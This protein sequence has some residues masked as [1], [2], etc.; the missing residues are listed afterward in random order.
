MKKKI[1]LLLFI[2]LLLQGCSIGP[3][4]EE[5]NY[6]QIQEKITL[7]EDFIYFL[8]ADNCSSCATFNKTLKKVKKDVEVTFYAIDGHELTSDQLSEFRSE[9]YS[10]IPDWYFSQN[11]YKTTSIYTPTFIKYVDGKA[12]CS[13]IGEIPYEEVLE[14]YDF[15]M[16]DCRF[17]KN[18]QDLIEEQGSFTILFYDSSNNTSVGIADKIRTHVNQNNKTCYYLKN[19]SLSTTEKVDLLSIVNEGRETQLTSL[20]SVTLLKYD[21]GILS[22]CKITT[23]TDA[24]ISEI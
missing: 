19:K 4:Y 11:G 8:R 18:Y 20:P 14:I 3:Q 5:V 12:Q 16:L 24:E 22:S 2:S 17:Y 9:A 15:N 6:D 21:N 7:K 10:M 1:F 13:F 23:L